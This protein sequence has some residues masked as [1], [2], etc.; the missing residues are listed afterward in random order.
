MAYCTKA[1][2]IA[3]Y[4]EQELIERTDRDN[5]PPE[6]IDDAVLDVAIADGDNEINARLAVRYP[7]PL[8]DPPLVLTRWACSLTRFFLY[9]DLPDDNPIVAEYKRVIKSLDMVAAGNMSLGP[10]GAGAELESDGDTVVFEAGPRD[11]RR[12]RCW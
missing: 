9:Q 8:V 7:A 10:D 11:F 2:L 5:T 12:S 3:R 6:A 4:G 1:D